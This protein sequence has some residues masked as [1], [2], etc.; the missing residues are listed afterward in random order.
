MPF[1]VRYFPIGMYLEC[2]PDG[3]D[4]VDRFADEGTQ[5]ADEV[6]VEV[7]DAAC[8][9]LDSKFCTRHSVWRELTGTVLHPSFFS[10]FDRICEIFLQ[11]SYT[12]SVVLFCC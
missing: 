8:A 3:A 9:W 12:D 5:F 1:P 2:F 10:L 6:P 7:A 11:I 4:R